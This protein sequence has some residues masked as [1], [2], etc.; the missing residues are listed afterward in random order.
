MSGKGESAREAHPLICE[1]PLSTSPTRVVSTSG[2]SC[3][4][5]Q[6]R[7]LMNSSSIQ[8]ETGPRVASG[9]VSSQD[10]MSTLMSKSS[11]ERK[12]MAL[13]ETVAGE[14]NLSECVSKMKFTFGPNWMRSPEGMV[15][16][17]LSSRT[18][19]S[20]SIHSGSMSPSQTIHERCSTGSATACS[21][22]TNLVRHCGATHTH[23]H[24]HAR[25][26]THTHTPFSR[27]LS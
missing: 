5:T 21:R 15:S 4:C 1:K 18:E 23:T 2:A 12:M 13:R 19:L 27:W 24:T 7:P 8:S 11:S 9:C 10:L 14:A 3:D 26:H 22:S 6:S 16:R 17:W 20:D 25:T